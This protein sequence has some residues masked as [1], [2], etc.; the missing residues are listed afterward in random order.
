MDHLL[1]ITS[2]SY[3]RFRQPLTELLEE[4]AHQR[5]CHAVTDQ[6][7]IDTGLIRVL[8]HEISGRAFLQDVFN[9]TSGE[10]GLSVGQFFDALKSSRRKTHLRG[11][12]DQYLKST[13]RNHRTLPGP[14]NF[15]ALDDF[16]IFAGDGHFHAAS[17]H[18]E[19]DLKGRKTA[20]GHL[21]TYNLRNFTCNHLALS[22]RKEPLEL[23]PGRTKKRKKT[24]KS[25]DMTVLKSL[26]AKTLRQG[27]PKGKKTLYIWDK[28]GIDFVQWYRWKQGSAIY[29]L[30]LEKRNMVPMSPASLEF[31]KE[32][33]VNAGIISDELA[34]YGGV[35][36]L[37]RI[38]YRCPETGQELI[39]L[40]NLNDIKKYPPGLIAQL[41][42]MR[43]DIEKVFDVF[44]NKFGEIKAW[45]K[46]KCAKEMQ[47]VF[48]T[49]AHNLLTRF[50]DEIQ[51]GT[52][53]KNET[54]EKRQKAR[55][56][57]AL[58]KVTELGKCLPK[59][60]HEWQR[61]KQTG[62]TFIRWLRGQ[63]F[64]TT[65]WLESLALLRRTYEKFK[66]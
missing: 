38:V 48:I 40:T 45:A 33:S 58:K 57:E 13:P 23:Q 56:S 37:R 49:L 41:Y 16:E 21:Y 32:D 61:I 9:D 66:A 64:V 53:L 26:D 14:A 52:G 5:T 34:G 17:S 63:L 29:F 44:K 19:R 12:L 8:K 65:S 43:W 46:S 22:N 18:D 39:F 20:V 50:E 55:L 10:A 35:A 36:Q 31:D 6:D 7:W 25:H 15:A 30:S 51:G 47:A 62:V 54:N 1:S 59:L 4:A 27:A 2:E 60:S 3:R 11:L 28:A 24:D 42:R